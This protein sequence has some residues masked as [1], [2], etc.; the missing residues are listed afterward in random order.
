MIRLAETPLYEVKAPPTRRRPSE[1][2][3]RA[4]TVELKPEPIANVASSAPLTAKNIDV[5]KLAAG[6][7]EEHAKAPWHFKL[8]MVLLA[9][10][11]AWRVVQ[12]FV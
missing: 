5:K 11:L 1:V 9:V 10:Y 4:L 3:A 7:D 12:L 2:M 8:L 6:S